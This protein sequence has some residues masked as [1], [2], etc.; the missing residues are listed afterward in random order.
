MSLLYLCYVGPTC[1]TW[2]SRW[3]VSPRNLDTGGQKTYKKKFV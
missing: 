2:G 3:R 1:W